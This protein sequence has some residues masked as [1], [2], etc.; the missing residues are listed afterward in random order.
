MAKA[1]ENADKKALEDAVKAAQAALETAKTAAQKDL[2]DA[3][4]AL[5]NAKTQYEEAL[6]DMFAKYYDYKDT[7]ALAKETAAEYI[8]KYEIANDN[9]AK[10]SDAEN[11]AYTADI[12]A[13]LKTILD[14]AKAPY[15][16]LKVLAKN[17]AEEKEADVILTIE[18][19]YA[20]EIGVDVAD[21]VEEEE[22]ANSSFNKYAVPANSIVYERYSN[23][24][25][26]I[27]NFNNYA[28]KVMLNN[29]YYTVD[30]YGYVI[31][32]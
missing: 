30:A 23:G 2:L 5:D 21:K 14:D 13:G 11:D 4:K 15:E 19:E 24:K 8:E 20:E 32:D 26:F 9:F 25:E 27:L 18:K 3:R 16:A 12:I 28:V 29:V 31:V 10:L 17:M 6:A 22:N 1:D 7:S